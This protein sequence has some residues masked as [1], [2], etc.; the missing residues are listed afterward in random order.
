MLGVFGLCIGNLGGFRGSGGRWM[1]RL[2]VRV[3]FGSV[4][5]IWVVLG[6]GGGGSLGAYA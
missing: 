3:Y 6:D 4:Q 2:A 5:V 1:F